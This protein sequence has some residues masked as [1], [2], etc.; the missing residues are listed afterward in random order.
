[1]RGTPSFVRQRTLLK[2]TRA[3]KGFSFTAALA[4]LAC[5]I[6]VGE[7]AAHIHYDGIVVRCA[8][9]TAHLVFMR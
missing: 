7:D 9:S 5:E 6:G 2:I 3:T 1:L 8:A 4:K